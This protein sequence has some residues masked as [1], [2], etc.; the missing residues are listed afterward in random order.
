MIDHSSYREAE[1]RAQRTVSIIQLHIKFY[2]GYE[3][4]SAA[5]VGLKIKAVRDLTF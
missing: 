5:H 3:G 4:V 2:T 1:V